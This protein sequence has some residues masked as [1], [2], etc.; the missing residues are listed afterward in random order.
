MILPRPPKKNNP[1]LYLA[2]C[3]SWDKLE[4]NLCTADAGWTRDEFFA[5]SRE[6]CWRLQSPSTLST[7][8]G[9]FEINSW[10]PAL[11]FLFWCVCSPIA[12]I[13]IVNHIGLNFS[14][15]ISPWKSRRSSKIAATP[16]IIII[17]TTTLITITATTNHTNNSPRDAP[18][19]R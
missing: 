4:S 19:T 8:L 15:I 16:I 11:I 13:L 17:I 7:F 1:R 5:V 2:P 14:I 10:R 6:S 12:V 9:T 3:R 18:T